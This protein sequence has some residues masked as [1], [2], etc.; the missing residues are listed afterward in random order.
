MS[1]ISGLS[2][3]VCQQ[4]LWVPWLGEAEKGWWGR[5]QNMR[6]ENWWGE[7]SPVA[8][9][10]QA[11]KRGPLLLPHFYFLFFANYT[12]LGL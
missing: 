12:G 6:T 2:G 8:H 11:P 4:S 5:D 9:V 7:Q 1:L 10:A 3:I